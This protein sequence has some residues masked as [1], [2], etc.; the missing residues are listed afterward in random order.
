MLTDVEEIAGA[1]GAQLT[2]GI[3]VYTR[4]DLH[5]HIN[6][7]AARY[8][9]YS[10]ERAAVTTGEPYGI[11]IYAFTRDA[12]AYGIW[13]TDASGENLGVGQG[14]SYGSGLLQF[15]HGRYYARISHSDHADTARE[16]LLDIG[17]AVV[18]EMGEEGQPPD[19]LA[20]LPGE[21]LSGVPV[22]F[23][24][25]A[26]LNHLYYVS[27]ENLLQLGPK[28]DVVFAEHVHGKLL[29]ARYADAQ[30]AGK[31]FRAF[32]A[33]YLE[34]GVDASAG[35]IVKRLEN[36]RY[37]GITRAHDANICRLV[38]DAPDADAAGEL[39]CT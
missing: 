28:V 18:A 36:G 3:N 27:D 8:L 25:Q 29:T 7:A 21:G 16:A 38:F 15:W 13:S 34:G 26:M 12:D 6:G 20:E 24:E 2:S 11:E 39:I 31:A 22:F 19:L 10:F 35:G 5:T 33:E 37:S 30:T 17:R 14:S 1:A 23:H 32:G 4:D 9:G